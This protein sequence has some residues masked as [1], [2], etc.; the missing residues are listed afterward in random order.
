MASRTPQAPRTAIRPTARTL[1]SRR[2]RAGELNSKISFTRTSRI[3]SILATRYLGLG[4]HRS[5]VRFR[6]SLA[7][8]L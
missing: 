7:S 4:W 1:Y 2:D 6:R 3:E 5:L 8:L